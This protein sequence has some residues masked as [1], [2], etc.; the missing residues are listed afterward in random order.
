MVLHGL[1]VHPDLGLLVGC[2]LEVVVKVPI[3]ERRSYSMA[4]D[5]K[6]SGHVTRK[7]VVT[8]TPLAASHPA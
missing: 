7:G 1:S 6:T 8:M 2:A 3:L 4:Q 5:V